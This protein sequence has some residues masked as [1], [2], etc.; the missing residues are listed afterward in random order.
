[1]Q[2]AIAATNSA[3]LLKQKRKRRIRDNVELYTLLL[4]VLIHI[5]IFCYIPMYGILIAFQDYTPGSP[6]LAFD[7]SV[8]WVGLK[9]FVNFVTSPMFYI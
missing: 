6:I 3:A 2:K 9:H 7:G 5:F 4:P 1:M 8:K